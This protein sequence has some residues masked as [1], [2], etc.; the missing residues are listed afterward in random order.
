MVRAGLRD[1]VHGDSGGRSALR[2]G[3]SGQRQTL[4][5]RILQANCA[6]TRRTNPQDRRRQEQQRAQCDNLRSRATPQRCFTCTQRCGQ[7]RTCATRVK[8]N[9][10]Q[11]EPVVLDESAQIACFVQFDFVRNRIFIRRAAL[12]TPQR[13]A[14]A[15]RSHPHSLPWL[16]RSSPPRRAALSR[17]RKPGATLANYMHTLVAPF[18]QLQKK[19]AI[20]WPRW[21]TTRHCVCRF[22]R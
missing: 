15:D 11:L 3:G 13:T 10:P 12:V 17:G 6:A 22:K 7:L 8:Q 19:I 16:P 5:V 2:Q 14:S 4:L 18:C 1:N 9:A 21:R 20:G